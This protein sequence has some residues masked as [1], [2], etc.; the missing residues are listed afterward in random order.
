MSFLQLIME[1]DSENIHSC[2]HYIPPDF[3]DGEFTFSGVPCPTKKAYTCLGQKGIEEIDKKIKKLIAQKKALYGNLSSRTKFDI[4]QVFRNSEG[5]S[6]ICSGEVQPYTPDHYE[7]PERIE[8]SEADSYSIDF[9]KRLS[10]EGEKEAD[11]FWKEF[12]GK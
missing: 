7:F 11:L 1:N 6:V 12:N 10:K 5:D 4:V 3:P 8:T 9:V 2:W